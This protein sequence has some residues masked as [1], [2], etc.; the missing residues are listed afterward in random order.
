[1][2][3]LGHDR[4]Q[5]CHVDH[6]VYAAQNRNSKQ[7]RRETQQSNTKGTRAIIPVHKASKQAFVAADHNHYWSWSQ[8]MLSCRCCRNC[9]PKYQIETTKAR[10]STIKHKNQRVNHPCTVNKQTGKVCCWSWPFLVM[11]ITQ[12]V[13]SAEREWNGRT[14]IFNQASTIWLVQAPTMACSNHH[15][16]NKQQ[17]TLFL[18]KM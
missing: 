16:P 17:I 1:M 3:I 9:R 11:I 4:S 14:T 5:C 18:W 12:V 10:N 13:V 6:V 8:Q 7:Q 15:S 2:T